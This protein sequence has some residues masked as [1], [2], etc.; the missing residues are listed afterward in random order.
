MFVPNEKTQAKFE[1]L[2]MIFLRATLIAIYLIFGL[3]KFTFAE[4][5]AIKPLIDYSPLIFWLGIF[6]AQGESNLVGILELLFGAALAV[7]FWR[8][9]SIL[10]VAGGV[11]SVICFL[12][13]LSFLAT[14][15]GMFVAGQ[16]PA[17][18]AN[19]LFVVKDIVLLATSC[20]LLTQ[21]LAVH[22]RLQ[23]RG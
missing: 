9:S 15:P 14:T 21:S 23:N 6:G 7:A 22:Q 18:T 3:Q 8:P 12:V 16:A 11:G 2:S 13:T 5:Q 4:A 1:H 19:G 10:A 20:V 17:M